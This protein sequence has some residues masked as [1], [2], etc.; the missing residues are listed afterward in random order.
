MRGPQRMVYHAKASEVIVLI[1]QIGA[2]KYNDLG[3]CA[4]RGHELAGAWLDARTVCTSR[5][6]TGCEAATWSEGKP[7]R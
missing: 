3:T 4:P 5:G 6:I 7:R 1:R 2:R